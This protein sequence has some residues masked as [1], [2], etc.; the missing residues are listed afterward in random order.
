MNVQ[1]TTRARWRPCAPTI[2]GR[3]QHAE[4][5]GL[6]LGGAGRRQAAGLDEVQAVG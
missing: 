5:V 4:L 1:V 3:S 2:A 6:A